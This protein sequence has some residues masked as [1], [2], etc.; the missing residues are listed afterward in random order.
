MAEHAKLSASSAHRWML[1][2]GSPAAEAP[3]PNTSSEAAE[4]GTFAHSVL[5][6]C[7]ESGLVGVPD[8]AKKK[9]FDYFLAKGLDGSAALAKSRELEDGVE[10]ALQ[11]IWRWFGGKGDSNI[12]VETK[13]SLAAIGPDMFGTCD[14]LIT[15]ADGTA[16][17]VDFKYGFGVVDIVDPD[18]GKHNP[19]VMYYALGAL[20]RDYAVPIH[21][22]NVAIIQ[23]RTADPIRVT[24]LDAMDVLT[25]SA[26]LQAAAIAANAPNAPR[27]PGAKQ[28]KYCRAAAHCEALK[29]FA[30]GGADVPSSGPLMSSDELAARLDRLDTMK[31][32]IK[33]IEEFAESEAK[34][35]RM[36]TGYGWK[37]GRGSRVWSKAERDIAAEILVSTGV[38]I[39]VYG[40]LS[41][42]E[43]E[44]AIGKKKFGEVAGPLV[45]KQPGKLK[46]AKGGDPALKPGGTDASVYDVK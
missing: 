24:T 5:Q 18:T 17:V 9:A 38:D 6:E 37:E 26:E 45:V 42:Y 23:P 12:E 3:F 46:L 43:A 19:Q 33:R 15:K 34:G 32:Y 29:A 14:V 21:T 2:P 35:G 7:L 31:V 25:W 8:A 41:P 40:C 44:K 1:C 22:V 36:P 4:D 13:L 11:N 30:E 16:W 20:L 27:V 10:L 28:C 39:S